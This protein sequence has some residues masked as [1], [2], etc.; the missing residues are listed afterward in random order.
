[1]KKIQF[2][3]LFIAFALAIGVSAVAQDVIVVDQ[4]LGTLEDAIIANGGDKIYQLK[5]GQWYGLKSLFEVSDSTLGGEGKSLTIIGEETD[6]MPAIIQVGNAADGAVFDALFKVFAD[7]TLENLFLS[8]QDFAGVTGKGILTLNAPVTLKIDR[9]IIDPA[10]VNRTWGGG[11]QADGARF[12]LT[13]SQIFNNGHMLGANDG[14][15]MGGMAWDT[16]WVENNSF[17]SSGQDFIGT[18]FH[19]VPNNQFIW[20][21]HNTFMWHDVWIKKSYNDQNN[22]FTNNLLHDISIFAQQYFWGQFFPDYK[23]GNTMLS[24]TCIDTLELEGGGLETL[25]SE[26][27]AYWA[28][29]NQYNSPGLRELPQYSV[30]NQGG[31]DG[32]INPLYL[33]PMLWEEA[34]PDYYTGGIEVV[35]PMDSSREARI[36]A[37]DVNWPYMKYLGNTYDV[38]PMYNN[39]KIG[40]VND[41]LGLHIIDMYRGWLWK[42]STATPT[43]DLP[44]YFYKPDEWAGTPN[45]EFPVVWPR[46]DGSYTNPALMNASIEGLPLGDLNWFPTAKAQWM[47]EKDAIEAHIMSL[48]EEKYQLVGTDK[49]YQSSRFSVYPNPANDVLQLSSDSEMKSVKLYDLTG[50]V[51]EQIDLNGALSQEI[52]ISNL[53]NGIYFLEASTVTGETFTSKIVKQ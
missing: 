22:F 10:G 32:K 52:N 23:Q 13:N 40:W 37:D 17:I 11:D 43:A 46:F 53:K 6:G 49:L 38:D 14:G 5:A 28:Y 21:N 30:D 50:K 3:S 26:R 1:M 15:F 16:L 31:L 12:Y 20:V 27:V 7:L 2:K 41:S 48:S 36:L 47:A 4:G 51:V 45:A 24:L 34:V 18:P 25:P 9:C 44:S 29:N 39:E 33:I 35:S 42:D 19:S 8:A